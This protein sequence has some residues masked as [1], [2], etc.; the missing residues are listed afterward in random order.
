VRQAAGQ[1]CA[2]HDAHMHLCPLLAV[3]GAEGRAVQR[4]DLSRKPIRATGVPDWRLQA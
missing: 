1:A 3:V 4:E 2:P